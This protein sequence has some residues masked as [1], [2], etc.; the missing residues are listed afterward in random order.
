MYKRQLYDLK[1]DPLEEYDLAATNPAKL[2]E[3]IALWDEYEKENG[4][5]IDQDLNLGYSG[6]NFHFKH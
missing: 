6:E 3:M 1:N 5:I 2:K 4:V